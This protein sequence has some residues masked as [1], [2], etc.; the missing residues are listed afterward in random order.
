MYASWICE[1]CPFVVGTMTGSPEVEH[2]AAPPCSKPTSWPSLST[3]QRRSPLAEDA[4]EAL[5]EVTKVTRSDCPRTRALVLAPGSAAPRPP[6]PA[7][8]SPPPPPPLLPVL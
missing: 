5:T 4:A 2:A 3:K 7:P 1:M 6:L 8:A